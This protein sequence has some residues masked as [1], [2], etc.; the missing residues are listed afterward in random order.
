MKNMKPC[1]LPALLLIAL[2]T[3]F[4][5]N[6]EKIK[7]I[8]TLSGKEISVDDMDRFLKNHMDSL[9]VKGISIAII[10]DAKVV[11]HRAIGI[12]NIYSLD[13]VN[14][15]TLFEAASISK[16]IFAYFVMR[17]V[18][19][20]LLNLDTPLYQYLPYPDIEHDHRYKLITARMVL[21]HTS[22]F[23]NWR[24]NNFFNQ[25][26]GKLF[27]NFT[28]GTKFSYS[29]EGYVY[30]AM[31]I[32]HLMNCN[33]SNLDSVFQREVCKPLNLKHAYF[34][35][36]VYVAKHLADGHDGDKITYSNSWDRTLFN[37]ACGLY[38]EARS[39]ANFLIAVMEDK[40]LKKE[41]MDEMLKKQVE[42]PDDNNQRKIFGIT[43]WS[44]GFWRKPSIYGINLAHGGNN[45]GY[46]SQ[47]LI[48]K[49][50]KFG[51][52]FFTNS[53]SCHN[54]ACPELWQ[55]LEPYLINGK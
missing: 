37:P 19:K 2:I 35:M 21:N 39:F 51:Y 16:P 30:L 41:S 29:G 7:K 44:L 6:V 25:Q 26:D 18:E 33:L 23:P 46:S 4:S 24:S 45:W 32:A 36:N 38:T 3:G 49:E 42:L 54:P 53:N 50:K 27:L 9:N 47:F 17:M 22:G 12:A 15:Q 5:S 55:K 20:G 8:K 1:L 31:V 10:N 34:G 14:E 48:N 11:Y 13:T 40:G 28:P 43:E 52:V